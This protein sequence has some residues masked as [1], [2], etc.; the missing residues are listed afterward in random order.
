[1]RLQSPY[2][3]PHYVPLADPQEAA[4]LQEKLDR[5]RRAVPPLKETTRKPKSI[6]ERLK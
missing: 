6:L 3:F 4:K 5:A 2:V 1:M